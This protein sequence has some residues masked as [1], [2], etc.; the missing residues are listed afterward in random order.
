[1]LRT[2]LVFLA[3]TMVIQFCL[4]I[5]RLP[6]SLAQEWAV[7]ER[8]GTI[9]VVDLQ[10]PSASVML[11]YAEGLVSIDKDSRFI[12][13]LAKNWRWI[14]DRSIEFKLRKGVIFHNGEVFDAEALRVNWEAY[15]NLKDPRVISFTNL[16]DE[17]KLEILD[18]YRV[19][20]TLPE[21]D[22]LAL[23]KFVCFFLAAPAYFKEHSVAE[24]KWLYLPEAGPWGTG[25]FMLVKGGVPYGAATD[26][27]VMEA[28]EDYWDPQYPKIKRVIFDNT[29]IANRKE[30]VELCRE[31]EGNVDVVTFLRPLDTLKVAESPHA[32]VVKSKDIMHLGGVF[33]QRKKDS[34]WKDI[35][36]RKAI[37]HAI[38]SLFRTVFYEVPI[39]EGFS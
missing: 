33:N 25:P 10:Q 13:C 23:V 28:F 39:F 21:P 26:R 8:R 2:R 32:K 6:P 34:K 36:L 31:T 17:T 3:I 27:I 19:R 1:M 16:P 15:R 12:P 24:K 9:K 18:R 37:N 29:L 20:F 4:S 5:A 14:N 35:R 7:P 38:N 11:N 30:A 22:D